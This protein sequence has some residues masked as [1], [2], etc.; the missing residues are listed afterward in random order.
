MEASPKIL[1]SFKEVTEVTGLSRPTLYRQMRAGQLGFV[2]V[3]RRTL[4]RP[5]DLQAFVESHIKAPAE[6]ANRTV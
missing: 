1:L 6:T 4:F 3:G 5:A 2:K